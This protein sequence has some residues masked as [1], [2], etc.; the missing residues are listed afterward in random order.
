MLIGQGLRDAV[1]PAGVHR[2]FTSNIV[3][4][5]VATTVAG[6][7]NFEILRIACMYFHPV[8]STP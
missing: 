1:T 6:S 2:T 5:M 3:A 8:R 7:R 4:V